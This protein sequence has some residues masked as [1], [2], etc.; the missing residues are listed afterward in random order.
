MYCDAV[1]LIHQKKGSMNLK[2]F[3]KGEAHEN[4]IPFLL[5]IEIAGYGTVS[6][7]QAV[8]RMES[9]EFRSS[10]HRI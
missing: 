6:I 9:R 8:S 7:P 2:D 4:C 3:L 5:K 10:V 1:L